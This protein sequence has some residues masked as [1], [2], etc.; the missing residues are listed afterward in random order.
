MNVY[1]DKTQY[2]EEIEQNKR[3]DN[4]PVENKFAYIDKT[5]KVV[6]PFG[7]YDY[8][9]PFGLGRKAIVAK[10]GAF[11][12]IDEYGKP[13]LPLSFDF[14]EQPSEYAN[15][16]LATK[17]QTVTVYNQNA[18][19]IPIKG[20]ESYECRDNHIIISNIHNKKGLLDYDGTQSIPFKYDTLYTSRSISVIDFI[21]RKGDTYGYISRKDEIIKPFTYKHIYGLKDDR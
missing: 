7:T 10:Q 1:L 21:A 11:G 4:T 20:I 5:K 8:A 19:I 16:F 12:I 17:G 2:L 14:I 3:S 9:T 15:I 13:I 18:Q 6:V